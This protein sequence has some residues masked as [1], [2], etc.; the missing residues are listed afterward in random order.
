MTLI[1]D[2]NNNLN[3]VWLQS[4]YRFNFFFSNN[5]LKK[6]LNLMS[7]TLSH[8]FFK[9]FNRIFENLKNL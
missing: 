8:V 3:P 9:I 1:I 4:V 6:C 5:K 2:R 7:F